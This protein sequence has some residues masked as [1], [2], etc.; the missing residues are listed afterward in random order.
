MRIAL[1][2]IGVALFFGCKNGSKSTKL[3]DECQEMLVITPDVTVPISENIE[4]TKVFM[5]N[6]CLLVRIKFNGCENSNFD[7]IHNGK[8]MKSLP[9]QVNLM[10]RPIDVNCESTAE[11]EKEFKFDIKKLQGIGGDG[12]A[13][14]RVQNFTEPVVYEY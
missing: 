13:I 2:I 12:K 14:I 9:P 7:L 6:D 3:V 1:L 5:E 8:V 11:L 10:L 4:V